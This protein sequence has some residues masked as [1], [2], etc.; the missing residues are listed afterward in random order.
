[1]FPC[2]PAKCGANFIL[3]GRFRDTERFVIISKLDWHRLSNLVPLFNPRNFLP[4]YA[5]TW[6]VCSRHRYRHHAR[7]SGDV[8]WVR[9]EMARAPARRY[10]DRARQLCILF[11]DRHLHHPQH[12][13]QLAHVDLPT[14]T[15]FKWSA[16]HAF[17]PGSMTMSLI[18]CDVA[19]VSGCNRCRSQAVRSSVM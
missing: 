14:L 17:K 13:A 9:A 18:F 15:I 8:E 11:S 5:R 4:R 3:G 6:E 16:N 12:R 19:V 1:M 2:Q 7:G 10:S